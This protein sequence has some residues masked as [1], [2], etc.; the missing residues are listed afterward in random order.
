MLPLTERQQAI[1][2][3]IAQAIVEKGYPPTLRE[4]GARMDIRST[5]GVSDHLRALERKGYLERIGMKS[6]ALKPTKLGRTFLMKSLEVTEEMPEKVIRVD[7]DDRPANDA[8]PIPFYSRIAAGPLGVMDERVERYMHVDPSMLRGGGE[9]FALRVK[10]ESMIDAGIHDGDT[11]FV[12]RQQTAAR[13][14][15]VVAVVGDEATVKRYFPEP[16]HIRLQPENKTMSPIFVR[17]R[18]MG[19]FHIL[20]VAVGLFRDVAGVRMM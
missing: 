11:L 12:K 8:V 15:I 2:E 6:R 5:N 9:T 20:G 18:E 1:L 7:R 10:G 13:G 17:K 14:E 3:Y 16:D 19:V 4:I